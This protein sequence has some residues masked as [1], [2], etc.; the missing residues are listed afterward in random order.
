VA[1]RLRSIRPYSHN[2][3]RC[4]YAAWVTSEDGLEIV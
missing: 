4:A 3:D 2:G 1:H